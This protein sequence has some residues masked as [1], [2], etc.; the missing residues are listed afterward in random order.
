MPGSGINHR[1]ISQI[2]QST[3]AVEYHTSASGPINST[4]S[5]ENQA[6]IVD[7]SASFGEWLSWKVTQED[8]V[9]EIIQ[10]LNPTL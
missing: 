5:A 2:I 9:K 1:N 6:S 10:T 7:R 8:Y 4:M 3:N